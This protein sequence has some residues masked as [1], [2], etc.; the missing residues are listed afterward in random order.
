MSVPPQSYAELRAE[1]QARMDS[2]APGQRRVARLLLTDPEATAFRTIA[3]TAREAGVHQSSLVRFATNLGLGGYPD[4]VKLCREHLAE[5]AHLV[6]RFE[7]AERNGTAG[8]LLARVVEHDQQN[9]AR[10]FERIEPEEWQRLVRLLAAAPRV[11]VMGLRKCLPVAQ[12]L[13]YLLHMVRPDVRLIAPVSGGL[14]DELRDLR[15]QDV[16][17]AI[18]IRRYTADTV[19]AI[20]YAREHGLHTVALTDDAASPLA[21][22]ADFPFFVETEGVTLLR[23]VTSFI[24]LVQAMST[25]VALETGARSRAELLLDE[26]LLDSFD[27]YA[28]NEPV[29]RPRRPRARRQGK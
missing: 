3:E 6:G 18:A 23:S 4:L 8:G 26:E 16:F 22:A 29:S 15:D 19:R 27:V 13:A 2:F 5:R 17:I 7:R 24:S 25:A 9:L 12:L 11:H 20:R 14:V 1:L 28:E 10:T 21:T